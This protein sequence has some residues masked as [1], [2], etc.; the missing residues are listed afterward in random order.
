MDTNHRLHDD[1]KRFEVKQN[2]GLFFIYRIQI[3][4]NMKRKAVDKATPK[5]NVKYISSPPTTIKKK[6]LFESKTS[7]F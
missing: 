1:C 6:K 2:M 3:N 5:L 7:H 4:M